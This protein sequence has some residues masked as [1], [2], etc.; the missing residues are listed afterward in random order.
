VL[1][2][3]ATDRLG[4]EIAN[5]VLLARHP[6]SVQ[7]HVRVPWGERPEEVYGILISASVDGVDRLW[8]PDAGGWVADIT[9]DQLAAALQSKAASGSVARRLCDKL[10]LVVVHE[11][12]SRSAAVEA[13]TETLS[14]VYATDFDR[15]I[16]FVPGLARATELQLRTPCLPERN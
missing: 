15:V 2:K 8:H 16:W 9:A 12:L 7:D 4:H 3:K 1:D 14:H 10:W 6:T 11:P 13:T 5:S